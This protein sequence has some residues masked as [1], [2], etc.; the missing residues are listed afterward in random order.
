MLN[1]VVG[2]LERSNGNRLLCNQNGHGAGYGPLIGSSPPM[3]ELCEKIAKVSQGDYAVLI[4]GETGTGKELVARCIHQ[5]GPRADRPFLP[6]DC[7]TLTSTLIECELFGHTRGAFT[8]A[9]RTKEGLLEAAGGGTVLLDEVNEM[10]IDLQPKL[11]RALEEKEIRRVGSVNRTKINA[12]VLAASNRDL[13]VA[14]RQG[15]IRQDLYYRLSVVTLRLPPLRERKS[16]MPLLV[17]HFLEKFQPPGQPRL[18]LSEGAMEC[19]MDHDWPGNVRE[20]KNCI[21]RAVGLSF[22]RILEC[23]DLA[24]ELKASFL[25][26]LPGVPF[27]KPN[28]F[29]PL[30]EL[31]RRYILRAL[32]DMGG[33]KLLAAQ[34]L[35]IGKTTLYRKLK[36]YR[37][38]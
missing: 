23:G 36:T 8:G 22:G 15:T 26:S 35:G 37:P 25:D 2:G 27:E 3:R 4:V 14:V 7:S 11:L 24:I 38:A 33:N 9:V 19:L 30:R 32:A 1:H 29:L 28:S 6:I 12:R 34:L 16:D 20:L 31:E 21:E 5:T 10:S 18:I 13:E 17:N